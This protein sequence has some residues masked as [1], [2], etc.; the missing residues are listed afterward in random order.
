MIGYY[1]FCRNILSVVFSRIDQEDLDEERLKDEDVQEATG[2][3][4]GS[5]LLLYYVTAIVTVVLSALFLANVS[6][7][8]DDETHTQSMLEASIGRNAA[9][10]TTRDNTSSCSVQIFTGKYGLPSGCSIGVFHSP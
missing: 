6:N 3:L 2:N 10:D 1:A 8:F 5:K 7:S 9:L 4:M